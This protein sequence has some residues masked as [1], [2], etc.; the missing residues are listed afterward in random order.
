MRASS[1][2]APAPMHRAPQEQRA[3]LR[4]CLRGMPPASRRFPAGTQPV[5]SS[6]PKPMFTPG[7]CLR[8]ALLRWWGCFRL[9][10]S[11]MRFGV[12]AAGWQLRL[13]VFVGFASLDS[14]VSSQKIFSVLPTTF[15][16]TCTLLHTAFSPLAHTLPTP[17]PP[18]AFPPAPPS[19][20]TSLRIPLLLFSHSASAR[21]HPCRAR[22][23][24][25][26]TCS[27]RCRLRRQ[28]CA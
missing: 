2:A 23:P 6:T 9:T 14:F 12:S 7:A 27:R 4:R 5:Q 19:H 20:L 24:P 25:H 17:P 18:S 22:W 3:C 16:T 1:C 28:R 26:R 15:H 8:F 10:R 13:R 11:V 21:V